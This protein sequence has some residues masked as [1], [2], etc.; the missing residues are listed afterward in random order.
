MKQPSRKTTTS[1][2]LLLDSIIDT[3]I[4]AGARKPDIL[5]FDFRF[6]LAFLLGRLGRRDQ[7]PNQTPR[8]LGLLALSLLARTKVA[9]SVLGK[10]TLIN[11]PESRGT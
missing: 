10:K 5:H 4:S 2:G 7:Q 11:S 3:Y 1:K 9:L 6:G 8:L